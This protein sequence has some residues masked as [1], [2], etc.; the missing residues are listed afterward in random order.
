ML[1]S[2]T[3]LPWTALLFA[4]VAILSACGRTEP[5]PMA[6]TL[7]ERHRWQIFGDKVKPDEDRL[8]TRGDENAFNSL[9]EL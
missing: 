8:L 3:A 1:R 9:L 5:G 7:H 6:I 4:A 2:S